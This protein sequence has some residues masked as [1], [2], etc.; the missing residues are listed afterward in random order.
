MQT[1]VRVSG[2]GT[3]LAQQLAGEVVATE[4]AEHAHGTSAGSWLAETT[5]LTRKEASALLYAG[6]DLA[7]FPAVA[8]AT[9][10]GGADRWTIDLRP[11]GV[12]QVRPPAYVD[13]ARAPRI[14]TRYLMVTTP[15]VP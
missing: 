3:A 13:R 2:Q 12:P 1:A 10:D 5:R 4:T 7:R 11:D 14:H 15:S 9:L 8:W 6:R